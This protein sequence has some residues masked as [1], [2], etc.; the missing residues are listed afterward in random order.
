MKNLFTPALILIT[1][2]A[3]KPKILLFTA[4]PTQVTTA[5]SVHLAW[6]T[7]GKAAMSFHQKKVIALPDSIHVLEF[8]LTATKWGKTSAPEVRQVTLWPPV[9]RNFLGLALTGKVGDSVIYTQQKD[10]GFAGFTILTLE[11]GGS[12]PVAITHEGKT[13]VLP[14]PGAPS[15]CLSG[16]TYSGN[17]E[18]HIRMTAQQRQDPHSIPDMYVLIATITP[19]NN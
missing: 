6:K 5:D 14:T 18:V 15:A 1:M 9:S 13:C 16:L 10:S 2:I 11:A 12:E 8:I 4:T 19:K 3:C 17:W 7:R